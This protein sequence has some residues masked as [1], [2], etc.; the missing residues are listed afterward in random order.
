MSKGTAIF[1]SKEFDE[2]PGI[3][4][5]VYDEGGYF[6]LCG[7]CEGDFV[8]YESQAISLYRPKLDEW[9][10]GAKAEVAK[11]IIEQMEDDALSILAFLMGNR[12]SRLYRGR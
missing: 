4:F 12:L 8:S 9:L 1:V 3:R 2:Y 7:V 6:R 5:T 10:P 11:K